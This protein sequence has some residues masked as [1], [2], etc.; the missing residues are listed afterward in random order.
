MAGVS[1]RPV[2]KSIAPADTAGAHGKMPSEKNAQA[3][4]GGA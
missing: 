1:A 2:A 3:P 4:S